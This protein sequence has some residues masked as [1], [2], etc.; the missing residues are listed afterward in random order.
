MSVFVDTSALYALLDRADNVHPVARRAFERLLADEE[1]LLT[2]NYVVLETVAL[3]QRRLGLGAVGVLRDALL[4]VMQ[5]TWVD[6]E[7]HGQA[8]AATLAS[9]RRNVS[10]VDRLSFELMRRRALRRA[11]AFDEHFAEQGFELVA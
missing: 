11:F 9:D 3:A 8:L 1:P 4:A 6:R 5:L 10:F 2:H 7:L